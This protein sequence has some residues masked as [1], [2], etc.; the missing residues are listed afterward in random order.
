MIYPK[1]VA[2]STT[3][4]ITI[5]IQ[6]PAGP[7]G[8]QGEQGNAGL[9]GP[10]EIGGIEIYIPVG[11]LNPNDVLYFDGTNWTSLPMANLTDGGTY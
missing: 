2:G 9:S 1:I 10:N 11:A 8:P 6:G 5:G 7:Q 4:I 3:T